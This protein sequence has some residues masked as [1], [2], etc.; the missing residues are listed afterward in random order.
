MSRFL[1]VEPGTLEVWIGPDAGP[2]SKSINGQSQMSPLR[3]LPPSHVGCPGRETVPRRG[4]DSA[5]DP[6]SVPQVRTL[7]SDD[8]FLR[9]RGPPAPPLHRYVV[10]LWSNFES[11]SRSE[12]QAGL[13]GTC[14][15]CP[16][17]RSGESLAWER[18]AVFPVG[19][20]PGGLRRSDLPLR[21]GAARAPRCTCDTNSCRCWPSG[22]RCI[23][24]RRPTV[25][26]GLYEPAPASGAR[27]CR[28][29]RRADFSLCS[30]TTYIRY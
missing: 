30:S 10:S 14:V 25:L 8:L 9:I 16:R 1:L 20:G 27:T 19:R 4:L 3:T 17:P 26:C 6:G 23:T 22:A 29:I 21:R 11:P 28:G 12:M 13:P 24:A 18:Q 5:R 15:Y 2:G 7:V